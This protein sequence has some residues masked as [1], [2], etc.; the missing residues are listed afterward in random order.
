MPHGHEVA[1]SGGP[2]PSLL[3]VDDD[4]SN[5]AVVA[6]VLQSTY[7]VRL[8]NG[9]ERALALAKAAPPDL[10]LL[11]VEMPTL[12]GY[13]VCDRLK[14]DPELRH[15]PVIFL[16][17]RATV[18][19]ETEGFAR[20]AVDYIHK[21]ISPPVLIAR[22]RTH[23]SLRAALGEAHHERVK[24]DELLEVVVPKAAAEELRRTGTVLPRRVENV[25]ILFCDLVEFTAFC[26]QHEP[27]L[28]VPR[29]DAVFRRM[30]EIAREHGVEKLKTIGDAF[31]AAAGI[32][33]PVPESLE[34][35]VRCGLAL[36]DEVPR[37]V[38]EWR[39]RV[40]VDVGTVVSGIVG[41]ERYQFDVWGDPVYVAAGLVGTG[42]PG[43]VCVRATHWPALRGRVRA[44]QVATHVLKAKGDLE[45]VEI[46]S[47]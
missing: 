18:E 44:R 3:V 17:G 35:A 23:L 11:D 5:L 28:V 47:D 10:I 4:A 34:A 6:N 12:D 19:D 43:S 39:A 29:L 26:D 45:V 22:V 13:A 32:L 14:A 30:E 1:V 36:A 31:M 8:A 25:A 7:R 41:G 2:K 16:T 20:G 46:V 9:G 37:I 24:A 33:Q 40:G 27:E 38:P 21:P 42:A 15:I